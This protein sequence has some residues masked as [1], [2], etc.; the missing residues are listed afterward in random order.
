MRGKTRRDRCRALP[1]VVLLKSRDITTDGNV[2]NIHRV[3][4]KRMQ[5][6][7]KTSELFKGYQI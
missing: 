7:N 5:W 6:K 2:I 1:G 4:V 3:D